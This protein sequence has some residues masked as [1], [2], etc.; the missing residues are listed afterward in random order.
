[1]RSIKIIG[2]DLYLALELQTGEIGI[3][4]LKG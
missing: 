2:D 1:M 3:Y 4:T